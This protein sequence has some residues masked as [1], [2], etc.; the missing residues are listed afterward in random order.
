LGFHYREVTHTRC[1]L[2]VSWGDCGPLSFACCIRGDVLTYY[3]WTVLLEV[4]WRDAFFTAPQVELVRQMSY[5]LLFWNKML[6]CFV[7]KEFSEKINLPK[8]N[9][10][11]N[12]KYTRAVLKSSW[13][14]LITPSR[15]FVD[16]RWRSLFRS[17]SLGKRCTSYNGPPTSRKRAADRLPQASGG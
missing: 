14:H 11:P 5:G 13:T 8:L 3:P 1:S 7:N 17:T 6:K 15:N 4:K 10:Y 2:S 9:M 12:S 16:V